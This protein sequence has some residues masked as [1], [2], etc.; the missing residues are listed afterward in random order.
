MEKVKH[1]RYEQLVEERQQ[2]RKKL[3]ELKSLLSN[4]DFGN[5]EDRE[6]SLI[7]IQAYAMELYSQI[8][9]ERLS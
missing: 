8:L 7:I 6:Q 9:L 2:L 1:P 3:Q 5:L 4:P